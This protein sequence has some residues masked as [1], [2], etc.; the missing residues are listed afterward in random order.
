MTTDDEQAVSVD[1]RRRIYARLGFDIPADEIEEMLGRAT[2]I[3]A[4]I[5]RLRELDVTGHEPQT[6]F[7]PGRYP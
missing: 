1:E 5:A 3:E 6:V 2:A 7:T 4:S